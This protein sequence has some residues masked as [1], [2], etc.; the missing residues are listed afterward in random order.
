[1]NGIMYLDR[2]L[3]EQIRIDSDKFIPVIGNKIG[4]YRDAKLRNPHTSLIKLSVQTMFCRNIQ[5]KKAKNSVFTILDLGC[6][7]GDNGILLVQNLL[8]EGFKLVELIQVDLSGELLNKANENF[9]KVFKNDKRVSQKLIQIDFN[10]NKSIEELKNS[11]IDSVDYAFSIKFLGNTPI[12]IN[13]AI[14]R[15]LN[16]VLRTNGVFMCQLYLTNGMT[17]IKNIIKL[18]LNDLTL[19]KLAMKS[20]GFRFSYE[21]NSKSVEN[22]PSINHFFRHSKE[23]YWTNI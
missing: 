13:K 8:K 14:A 1:M 12:K 22:N 6:G 9:K 23:L 3:D 19:S 2:N 18:I 17:M 20:N 15:L 16:G 5:K 7:N 10:N 21:V 11:L 4:A